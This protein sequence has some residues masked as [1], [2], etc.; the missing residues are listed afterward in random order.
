MDIRGCWN[1]GQVAAFAEQ[2]VIPLRLAVNDRGGF[3]LVLS[4]WFL[5]LDGALWCATRPQAHVM[6]RLAADPCCAF[7]IA[8]DTPPYRG[9]RG[10]GKASLHPER[11]ADMLRALM[12]RYGIA[13]ASGLAAKLLA[14]AQDEVAIRIVPERLTSWD[15]SRRMAGATGDD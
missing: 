5:P 3:P 15:F 7:E 4:L 6:Q 9:I 12:G 1:A 8:A 2:A 13:P 11:G 10:K 14:R